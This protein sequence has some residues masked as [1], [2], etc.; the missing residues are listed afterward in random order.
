[1]EI[2]GSTSAMFCNCLQS[3]EGVNECYAELRLNSGYV[4]S[5][6][7]WVRV[8]CDEIAAHFFQPNIL[9]FKRLNVIC[10]I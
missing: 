4:V 8:M 1:V 2:V 5:S 6:I 7:N 10:F 9:N 3:T